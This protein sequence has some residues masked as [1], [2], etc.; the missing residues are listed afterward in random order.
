MS[1]A[2]ATGQLELPA[3]SW[4][5]WDKASQLLPWRI[6]RVPDTSSAPLPTVRPLPKD[7]LASTIFQL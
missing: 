6:L 4:H 2:R 1:R 7:P 5:W 3:E